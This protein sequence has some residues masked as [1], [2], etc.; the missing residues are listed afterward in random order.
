VLLGQLEKAEN[1]HKKTEQ[2]WN[3]SMPPDWH[4]DESLPTIAGAGDISVVV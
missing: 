2:A 3:A 1:L 4:N